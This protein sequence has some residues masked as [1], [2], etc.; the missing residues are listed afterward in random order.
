VD[1]TGVAVRMADLLEGEEPVKLSSL[2]RALAVDRG[3]VTGTDVST[4][5]PATRLWPS[6]HGGVVLRLRGL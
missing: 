3:L 6:D 4:K 1:G 2:R 5:D